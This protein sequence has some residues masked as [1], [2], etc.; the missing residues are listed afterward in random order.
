MLGIVVLQKKTSPPPPLPVTGGAS[1]TFTCGHA[2]PAARGG[3]ANRRAPHHRPHHPPQSAGEYRRHLVPRPGGGGALAARPPSHCFL[4]GRHG[5]RRARERRAAGREGRRRGG[6]SVVCGAGP[7]SVWPGL[8]GSRWL[9]GLWDMVQG[10]A[11]RGG[12]RSDAG[13][14]AAFRTRGTE[15]VLRSDVRFPACLPVWDT[16]SRAGRRAAHRV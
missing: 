8:R 13:T 15:H 1:P 6:R 11:M 9:R 10:R 4:P 3:Q 14:G 16:G 12:T 7:S 5:C 2:A